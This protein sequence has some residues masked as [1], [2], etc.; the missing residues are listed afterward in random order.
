MSG[1]PKI[2][3]MTKNPRIWRNA[4]M[5][6]NPRN[7]RIPKASSNTTNPRM[8]TIPRIL[9]NPGWQRIR[10]CQAIQGIPGILWR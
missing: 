10:E 7:Q 9:R 5:F 3:R 2:P 8:S 1:N 6:S 4:T